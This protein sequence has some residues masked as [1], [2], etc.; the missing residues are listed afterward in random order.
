LL[1]LWVARNGAALGTLPKAAASRTHSKARRAETTPPLP[2][3]SPLPSAT[4]CGRRRGSLASSMSIVATAGSASS[5]VRR[6]RRRVLGSMVVSRSWEGFISPRPLKRWMLTLPF[7]P[8]GGDLRQAAFALA[9]VERVVNMFTDVDAVQRRHGHEHVSLGDELAEVLHEE[10]AEQ[11]GDVRA[12]GVGV[13]QDA[14]LAVAQ[15]LEF[16]EP[17]STPRATAMSCTSCEESTSLESTSHVFRILP[18]SG[19]MAWNSRSRACFAEPPAES[20]STRNSSVRLR[21]WP[22]SRPAC[23]GARG[24]R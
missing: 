10:R 6:T 9:V 22:C 21:S 23:R 7:R 13:G 15:S 3:D 17:G 5:R 14:D 20:P 24:R 2:P 11:R 12:V 1:P 8:L 18:R 4:P 19:M 16:V